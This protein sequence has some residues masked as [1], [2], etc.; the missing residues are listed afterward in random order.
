MFE[1]ETIVE[2]DATKLAQ[3][4]ERGFA[5]AY[6]NPES[7]QRFS[8]TLDAEGNQRYGE[9]ALRIYGIEGIGAGKLSLPYT[10]VQTHFPNA[11]PGRAQER[12][13]CVSFSTR[14]AVF[15]SYMAELVYGRNPSRHTIPKLTEEAELSGCVSSESYYWYRGHSGDGWQCAEAA[16]IALHKSGM[17]LRQNYPELGFDLTRYSPQLAGRWGSSPPPDSVTHVGQRTLCKNATV[18]RTYESVRDMLATGNCLSSCGSE[19]FV[20]VRNKY[21]IADRAIGRKWY[22]AMAYIAVDDRPETVAREGCGLV[23]VCN[24]WGSN[25]ISGER[26]I[27]NTA[28]R[29]PHGCFWA[30]WRDIDNRYAIAFGASTGWPA[31][32]MPDWGLGGIV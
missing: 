13:D 21:G 26:S 14:T 4:Y 6:W 23:L 30:R 2:P 22:H 24:S 31:R 19:A 28:L 9:D 16:D 15:G 11:L 18:C 8:D 32:R 5:G 17:W 29:I 1:R 12:G 3:L 20:N 7:A 10:A 25:W 27:H